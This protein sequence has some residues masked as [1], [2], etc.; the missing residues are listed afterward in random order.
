M[1]GIIWLILRL[2]G[3]VGA[4]SYAAVHE[5]V[6]TNG[7]L[8]LEQWFNIATW[9]I[10]AIGAFFALDGNVLQRFKR[11]LE[12]LKGNPFPASGLFRIQR[13]LAHELHKR[14]DLCP[15]KRRKLLA[16]L[17]DLCADAAIPTTTM[18]AAALQQAESK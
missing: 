6:A 4:V 17:N 1:L 5:T 8:G 14:S 2:L 16:D 18:A 9:L 15:V 11:L 12:W 3:V 10:G 7:A 13:D